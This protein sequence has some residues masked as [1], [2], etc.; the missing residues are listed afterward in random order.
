MLLQNYSSVVRLHAFY[1]ECAKCRECRR[2]RCPL[3]WD[4]HK[5]LARISTSIV[6]AR[7]TVSGMRS[8]HSPASLTPTYTLHR[9]SVSPGLNTSLTST[10]TASSSPQTQLVDQSDS[11]SPGYRDRARC[12]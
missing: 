3:V 2:W 11:W 8:C 4:S 6:P 12:P 10:G 5:M 9:C 1:H 7:A